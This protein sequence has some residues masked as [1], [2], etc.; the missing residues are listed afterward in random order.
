MSQ[1]QKNG[2]AHFMLKEI[3]EQ[4]EV[5]QRIFT[6]SIVSLEQA[7]LTESYRFGFTFYQRIIMIAC[8]TAYHAGLV[9][10]YFIEKTARIPVQVELASEFRFTDPFI[11]EKT[12]IIAISQ[13]GETGD[14]LA[15]LRLAKAKGGKVL[16]ITNVVDS[17]IA[18][19]ADHV[20]Y[21]MAGKEI[22]VAS[23]KAYLAQLAVLYLLGIQI[24][25]DKETL[26]VIGAAK[27]L[28][29][30]NQMPELLWQ[31]LLEEEKLAFM[32]GIL[33][34]SSNAFFLG[35][36]LDAALAMEGSLKLKET[37]YIHSEAY[38]AGEFRHGPVALVEEGSPIIILATQP[39]FAKETADVVF[40]LRSRGATVL[41]ITMQTEKILDG[42]CHTKVTLPIILPEFTPIL[43]AAPLQL[44]AY[45]TALAKGNDVDKPRNLVKSVKDLN[46]QRL[47][48][49]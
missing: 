26:D 20:V 14:T 16:A 5:L 18:K 39:M 30:L 35:R 1:D 37:S 10:K 3:M 29:A 47:S 2:Y 41:G 8:G 6:D 44:L 9:G 33:E 38:P 15:S 13:S 17:T 22:S 43:G 11:D 4:P 21:T 42:L 12:L 36:G 27:Y 40:E 45:K 49:L 31:V 48:Y 46:G 25:M 23:T 32:T 24:A 28:L 34:K 7:R 19:E